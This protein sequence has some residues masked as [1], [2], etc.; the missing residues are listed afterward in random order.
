MAVIG[1]VRCCRY[2]RQLVGFHRNE[3][4]DFLKDDWNGTATELC[5]ALTKQGNGF[6]LTPAIL[7]KKLKALSGL[8]RKK[9]DI[10]IDFER[11]RS[12]RRILLHRD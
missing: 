6:D 1:L 11:S 9:Y 5:E 12:S 4:D 10:A 2:W 8:F 3:L 7:T